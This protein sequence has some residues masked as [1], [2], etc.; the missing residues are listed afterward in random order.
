MKKF[1]KEGYMFK[2]RL[3]LCVL[4][5]IIGFILYVMIGMSVPFWFFEETP[6]PKESTN[7]IYYGENIGVDRAHIVETN[8]EALEIRLQM[9]EDAQE[10]IILSTY[11]MKE[12]K[13]VDD[14]C[15][16]LLMAAER[17]VEI[18]ILI[19]GLEGLL[20]MSGNNFFHAIS[21]IPNIEIKFY[22]PLNILIPWRLQG[23]HA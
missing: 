22:N 20:K 1:K 23:R 19:D 13:S 4:L 7:T 18:R 5:G 16:A 6:V 11:G 3:L 12:G 2:R 21:S 17:G 10:R 14:I 15:A 9:I 8:K